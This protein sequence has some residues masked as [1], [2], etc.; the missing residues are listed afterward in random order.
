MRQQWNILM[1]EMFQAYLKRE[2]YSL[3]LFFCFFHLFTYEVVHFSV[4][5]NK[6]IYAENEAGKLVPDRFLLF[7]KALY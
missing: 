3:F 2:I 4:W 6:K 5:N 7:K 1:V